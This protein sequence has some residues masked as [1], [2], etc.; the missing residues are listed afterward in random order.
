ML[1]LL[2]PMLVSVFLLL[3]TLTFQPPSQVANIT[4]YGFTH[5]STYEFHPCT[6]CVRY[7]GG[8][9]TYTSA[10]IHMTPDPSTNPAYVVAYTWP[11][12]AV[13]WDSDGTLAG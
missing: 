11:H 12:Q 5:P 3:L 6:R 1:Y 9:H 4:F 8:Y 13:L 7:E 2:Y 10:I